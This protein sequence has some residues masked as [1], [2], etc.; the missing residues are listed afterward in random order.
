MFQT[1]GWAY[2]ETLKKWLAREILMLKSN[3]ELVENM[4]DA[5]LLFQI[6]RILLSLSHLKRCANVYFSEEMFKLIY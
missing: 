3:F 1:Q 6:S 2:F 4:L 5:L